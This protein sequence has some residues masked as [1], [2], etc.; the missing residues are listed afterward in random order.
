MYRQ[1]NKS[2]R[3]LRAALAVVAIMGTLTIPAT[4]HAMDI[5]GGLSMGQARHET[6]GGDLLG[7][8]FSGTVDGNDTGWKAFVGLELWEKYVGAEFG[9][10]DLGKASAKGTVGGVASSA[11]S[12]ATAYT[13]SLVGLIPFGTQ[14]GVT[15]RLGL[16]AEKIS[17]HTAGPIGAG[18]V[19]SAHGSDMKIFGGLGFQHYFSKTWGMRVEAERH[20][21]GSIGSPYVNMISAGVV[22]QFEK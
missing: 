17:V 3:H 7:S 15:I 14:S 8:G 4:G 21:M 1:F 10:A 19:N 20:N 5:Y 13:A 9:Y 16:A 12:A 2:K 11:T 18:A 6:T 22:Y